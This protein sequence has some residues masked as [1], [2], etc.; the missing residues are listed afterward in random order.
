[1][2][3][4]SLRSAG[5]IAVVLSLS[6]W[7]AA[8]PASSQARSAPRSD[9]ASAEGYDY[10]TLRS[11]DV[12]AGSSGNNLVIRYV[13]GR[14][15]QDGVLRIALPTRSWPTLLRPV[16]PLYSDAAPGGF[17]V[18]PGL[19]PD[20]LVLPEP[21][22]PSESTCGPVASGNWDV[23]QI[24]GA[25]LITVRGV[26]C[27]AGQEL[28]IRL[29]GIQAPASTGSYAVPLVATSGRANP[30]LSVARVRVVPTPRTRLVVSTPDVVAPGAP[31]VIQVS[32]VRPNG[33]P[34][35]SY[36]GAVAVVAEDAPDCT[37]VPRDGS[38]AYEFTAADHGVAYI[39]VSLDL[40]VSHHLRV[41]D[42]GHGAVDGVS[43]PFV[44]SGPPPEGGV[45]CPVSFH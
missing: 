29:E 2:P 35:T 38:V 9:A 25:Q 36:R 28:A 45:I 26:T 30:R 14:Q 17:S 19:T 24:P 20:G 43:P 8:A 18:R 5:L 3:R 7:L 27:A 33:R 13:A 12:I 44:V 21:T 40:T 22:R 11:A 6:V 42:V 32:A 10:H 4:P 1:M 34:D 37:L 41:Y 39:V 23:T 15:L 16:G 31:F